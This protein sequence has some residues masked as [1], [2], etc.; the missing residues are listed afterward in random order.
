MRLKNKKE[1]I[2]I[3][4]KAIEKG[5]NWKDFVVKTHNPNPHNNELSLGATIPYFL[6][7]KEPDLRYCAFCACG[8]ALQLKVNKYSLIA[9]E[10]AFE[11]IEKGDLTNLF[12]YFGAK[13]SIAVRQNYH[14]NLKEGDWSGL[15]EKLKSLTAEKKE[16]I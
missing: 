3:L 14:W 15:R 11:D 13:P 10:Y 2:K 5:R 1:A 7:G 6:K 16:Y 4:L 8:R 9:I 12:L